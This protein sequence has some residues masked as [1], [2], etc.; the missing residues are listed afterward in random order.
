MWFGN[1]IGLEEVSTGAVLAALP[2]GVDE[3]LVFS[4]DG[5]L[6]AAT[7]VQ[8]LKSAPSLKERKGISLIETATGEEIPLE[9]GLFGLRIYAGR[10]RPGR[11]GRDEL[12]SGTRT[13]VS[14]CIE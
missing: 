11:V 14:C 1:R 12:P 3:P 10:S 13:R 8:P 7:I 4:P 6:V 9:H 2:E 5:R